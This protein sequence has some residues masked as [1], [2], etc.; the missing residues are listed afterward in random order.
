VTLSFSILKVRSHVIF[1][2]ETVA[3]QDLHN[4][5]IYISPITERKIA[6]VADDKKEDIK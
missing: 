6:Q 4:P 2:E 1:N 5:V 3:V